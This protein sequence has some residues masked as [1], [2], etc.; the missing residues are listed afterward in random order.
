MW[1]NVTPVFG[2]QLPSQAQALVVDS[3]LRGSAATWSVTATS[4]A[5]LD[6]MVGN[7]NVVEAALDLLFINANQ[8]GRRRRIRRR[9]RQRKSRRGRKGRPR[10]HRRLEGVGQ[11]GV[12]DHRDAGR[13]GH[14]GG[15]DR[16]RQDPH[17][18]VR[19]GQLGHQHPHG[20]A[21]KPVGPDGPPH[22]GRVVERLRG[23]GGRG[24]GAHRHRHRPG[25]SVRLP[26]GWCGIVGLKVTAGRI[27][28][29]G[30]L[31]LSFTLDTPGPM[32]RSVRTRPSCS[33]SSTDRTRA[34]PRPSSG[35]PPIPCR[36]S[37]AACTGCASR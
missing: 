29:H 31:P 36:P 19:D 37:T 24:A 1:L 18:G 25:G 26:A 6:V 32:A 9:R 27:S 12:A 34:T 5:Q 23:G 35:P 4:G 11:A 15:H 13:A 8:K 17:R 14:R 2:G 20:H 7:D 16:P 28:T 30:V 3:P 21:A 10:D 33:A 22:A